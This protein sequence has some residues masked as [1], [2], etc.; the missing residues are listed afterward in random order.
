MKSVITN[1]N[2]L[3]SRRE[4]LLLK[5]E[6]IILRERSAIDLIS[7]SKIMLD[8]YVEVEIN[9]KRNENIR[10]KI[11]SLTAE[12]VRKRSEED[13]LSK[14]HSNMMKM[15]ASS[16]WNFE[17][18]DESFRELRDVRERC[19]VYEHFID[20]MGKHG[21]AYMILARKLPIINDEINKILSSISDFSVYLEHDENDQS[22]NFNLRYG[23]FKSRSLGL[24][25]GAEKFISSIAIRVALLNVTNLPKANLFMIDE[26]FGSLDPKHLESMHRMFVYLKTV[27]EN[28]LIISHVDDLKDMVDNNIEISVDSEGYAHVEVTS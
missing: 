27:F 8:R 25:C 24:A 13:A 22:L 23:D 19:T 26:G 1:E 9:L 7:R 28:V 14:K 17:K 15:L 10:K 5:I 11:S 20:T 12:K 4:K 18:L 2:F 21:I 16:Q 3:R 6:N